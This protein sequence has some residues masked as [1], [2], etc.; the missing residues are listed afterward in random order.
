MGKL[1]FPGKSFTA[2][3]FDMDGTLLTSVAVAERVWGHWARR[4]GLDPVTFLPTIH[5][6]RAVETIARLALPNVDAKREAEAITQAEIADMDGV[7]A[8]AGAAEFLKSLPPDRWAI[9]TS[10]P[11][12]LA[13][14]RLE[15]AGL[16]M[17]DVLVTAEDVANGKPAPDCFLL[18]A[19]RLGHSA[20]DCVVF[21][22]A[23]AGVRAAEAAGSAVVVMRGTAS[24]PE[25]SHGALD[26]YKNVRVRAGEGGWLTVIATKSAD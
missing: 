5:G 13:L 4:H 22:D 12:R 14:R 24:D 1:L 3:L 6:V 11:R 18:A 17:P 8:I 23:V 16:P 7:E 20:S 10:A 15:A 25:S 2:L 9:V 26:D 19:G 21:E